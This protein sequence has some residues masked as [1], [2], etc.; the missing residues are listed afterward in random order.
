MSQM[1]SRRDLLKRTLIVL[2]VAAS[3][4]AYRR[5]NGISERPTQDRWPYGYEAGFHVDD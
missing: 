3:H 2:G 1:T 5:R 4:P